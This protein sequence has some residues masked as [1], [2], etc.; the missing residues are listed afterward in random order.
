MLA[1]AVPVAGTWPSCTASPL[2]DCPYGDGRTAARVVEV[3]D[4]PEVRALLTPREPAPGETLVP[5]LTGVP[6]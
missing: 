6:A 5:P 3:L 4:E 2:C 1:A